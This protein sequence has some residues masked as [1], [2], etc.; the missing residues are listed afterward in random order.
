MGLELSNATLCAGRCGG[1][2]TRR[3]DSDG[4]PGTVVCHL[5]FRGGGGN[6]ERFTMSL[7]SQIQGPSHQHADMPEKRK[8]SYICWIS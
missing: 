4:E 1:R 2:D 3:G 5:Y 6:L 8:I 7:C